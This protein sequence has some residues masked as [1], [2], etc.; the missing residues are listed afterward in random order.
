MIRDSRLKSQ[1]VQQ[2]SA[3]RADQLAGSLPAYAEADLP[4]PASVA[5]GFTVWNTDEVAPN[6]S[7]GTQWISIRNATALV[8]TSMVT[9]SRSALQPGK[10]PSPIVF[11]TTIGLDYTAVDDASYRVFKIPEEYVGDAS[12][13]VHWTKSGDASEAGNVVRWRVS[14]TVWAGSG[15]QIATV[16]PTVVTSD[17]TYADA[18]TDTTR[19]VYRTVNIAASGFVAD[20][21]VGLKVDYDAAGTTLATS[22][23]V[24][25]SCDLIYRKQ[26]N[27]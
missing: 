19:I 25:V 11:G 24:L 5:P 17:S 20:Y 22:T 6:Y 23:P 4:A 21:Y 16:A 3:D 9:P 12:F 1:T 15:G 14:Y 2:L 10:G 7:D 27:R 26:I 8:H 13:H 18:S